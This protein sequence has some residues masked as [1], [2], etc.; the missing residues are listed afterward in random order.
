M[1]ER[2]S[3]GACASGVKCGVVEWVKRNTL[4]WFDH[5]ERMN[6]E[7]FV[8][9]VYVS[10]IEDPGRRGKPLG[11]WKDGVK[12]YM[13]ERGATRGDGLEQAGRECLDRERWRLFSHGHPFGGRSQK[14]RGARFHKYSITTK[15]SKEP[16]KISLTSTS[17]HMHFKK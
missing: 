1:Y 6:N 2:W 17:I 14:E 10:E 8:K 9:I 3:M 11:R 4:R 12:K 15:T 16:F 7:E 5:N 13:S